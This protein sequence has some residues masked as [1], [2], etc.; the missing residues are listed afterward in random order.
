[1]RLNPNGFFTTK[2]VSSVT[3]Y[4][5]KGATLQFNGTLPISDPLPGVGHYANTLQ[6]ELR[7]ALRRCP[8]ECS[9]K[10]KVELMLDVVKAY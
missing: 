3:A 7:T 4:P 1:M 8:R 2:A 5:A 10:E 6:V 9:T